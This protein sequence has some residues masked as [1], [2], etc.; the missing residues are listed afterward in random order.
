M[1]IFSIFRRINLLKPFFKPYSIP[2]FLKE[3]WQLLGVNSPHESNQTSALTSLGNNSV[4]AGG[5][6]LHSSLKKENRRSCNQS[7]TWQRFFPVF[8]KNQEVEDSTFFLVLTCCVCACVSG[9]LLASRL[10]M[11]L[12]DIWSRTAT[13][14]IRAMVAGRRVTSAFMS[15]SSSSNWFNTAIPTTNINKD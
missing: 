10:R 2:G 4:P 3:E 9:P 14:G 12:S 1:N 8:L 7:S 15:L 5:S 13:G 6:S 11:F